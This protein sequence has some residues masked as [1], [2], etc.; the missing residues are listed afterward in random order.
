MSSTIN[1]EMSEQGR[2]TMI[3]FFN[4]DLIMSLLQF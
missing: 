4:Q 3:R 1:N 2:V